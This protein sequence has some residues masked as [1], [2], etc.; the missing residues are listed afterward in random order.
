MQFATAVQWSIAIQARFVA[1]IS[2]LFAVYF[3]L[4]LFGYSH[5]CFK[6]G[7]VQHYSFFFVFGHLRFERE[8]HVGYMARVPN[9][10]VVRASWFKTLPTRDLVS[11]ITWL[12]EPIWMLSKC[13]GFILSLSCI[14]PWNVRPGNCRFF[15]WTRR[16]EDDE[17]HEGTSGA[18][19]KVKGTG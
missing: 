15:L 5:A 10:L 18:F 17:D 11:S 7:V 4:M 1:V 14:A 12:L 13:A 2:M 8:S 9:K 16:T 3:C 6:L 19:Q